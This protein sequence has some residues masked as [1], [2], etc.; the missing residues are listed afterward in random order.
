MEQAVNY[1]IVEPQQPQFEKAPN[2][3]S[4]NRATATMQNIVNT[5]GDN[6]IKS[7]FGIL[8]FLL[9]IIFFVIFGKTI[10][11]YFHLQNV[12]YFT[13]TLVVAFILFIIGVIITT[14][15]LKEPKDIISILTERL[16]T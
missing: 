10:F 14:I 7:C 5:T 13:V 1:Q 2:D 3:A 16:K 4:E 12:Y 9:F 6:A 15:Q 11:S 8:I